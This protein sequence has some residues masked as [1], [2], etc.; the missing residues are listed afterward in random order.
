MTLCVTLVLSCWP[1]HWPVSSG[2]PSLPLSGRPPSLP[3][4]GPV[5]RSAAETIRVPLWYVWAPKWVRGAGAIVSAGATCLW[6][7][8]QRC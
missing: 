8:C 4:S 1:G 6:M 3:L 7:R 2:P 5:A